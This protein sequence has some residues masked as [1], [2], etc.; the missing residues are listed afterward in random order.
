[1][2]SHMWLPT[3]V[4][5]GH[6]RHLV[7]VRLANWFSSIGFQFRVSELDSHIFCGSVPPRVA[8]ISSQLPPGS[9]EAVSRLFRV[10]STDRQFTHLFCDDV[11]QSALALLELRWEEPLY[12]DCGF[13][14]RFNEVALILRDWWFLLETQLEQGF[15]VRFVNAYS[16]TGLGSRSQACQ[17]SG[18]SP[19]WCVKLH[20]VGSSSVCTLRT[21]FGTPIEFGDIPFRYTSTG[22]LHPRRVLGSVVRDHLGSV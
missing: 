6:T 19:E 4:D 15:G 3:Q 17:V 16:S 7:A 18:S 9:L 20:Y 11:G 13:S 1:V 21:C 8:A 22:H 10:W 14:I 2:L 12:Y 5:D